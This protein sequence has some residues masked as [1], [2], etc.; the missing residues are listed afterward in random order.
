VIGSI[1]TVAPRLLV[2][3]LIMRDLFG[4]AHLDRRVT[5]ITW[6]GLMAGR[7]RLDTFQPLQHVSLTGWLGC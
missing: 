2:K 1:S 4:L 3:H 7:D 5:R 6:M